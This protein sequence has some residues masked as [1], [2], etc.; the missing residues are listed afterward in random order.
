MRW[1]HESIWP[2]E[3]RW[4]EPGFVHDGTRLACA[5]MLRGG[6]T[7]VSDMYFFPDAAISA[8]Q[9]AGIRMV[10]GLVVLEF[11]TAYAKSCPR[12]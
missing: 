7:T 1:L 3:A 5:E 4:V 9:R 2:A 11:A 10:A 8:A 6:V 12:N